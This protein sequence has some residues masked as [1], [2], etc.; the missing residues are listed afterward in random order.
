MRETRV[1]KNSVEC[2]GAGIGTKSPEFVRSDLS[3]F[4]GKSGMSFQFL[5]GF[6][7]LDPHGCKKRR[8]ISLA[9]LFSGFY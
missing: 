5:T 4:M 6:L 2:D 3:Y 8:T 7:D 9:G 1:E